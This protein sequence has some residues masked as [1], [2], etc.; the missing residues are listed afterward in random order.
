[1]TPDLFT[2]A[3]P[4]FRVLCAGVVFFVTLS[5]GIVLHDRGKR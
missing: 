3:D 4:S 1:M 5:V 2:W